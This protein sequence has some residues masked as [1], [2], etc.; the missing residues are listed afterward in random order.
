[1]SCIQCPLDRDLHVAVRIKLGQHLRRDQHARREIQ[2]HRDLRGGHPDVGGLQ[3]LVER[4]GQRR[5]RRR[6]P[7]NQHPEHTEQQRA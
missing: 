4:V 3:V 7:R 6:Q 2:L 5:Y 1:M